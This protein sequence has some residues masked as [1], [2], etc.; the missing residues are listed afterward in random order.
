MKLLRIIRMPALITFSLLLTAV[1]AIALNP[2]WLRIEAVQ[3]DLQEGSQEE[4][5]FQRIK[6]SLQPQFDNF[7]GRYFWEL[8]LDTVFQTTQ[9]DRRVKKVSIFREFPSRLRI[10]VEPHTPVL[11]FLSTDHRIYP[12]ATDATL[13]PP[14]PAKEAP[15]LPL[16]RGEELKDEPSLRER[17]LEL[18][19]QI[20]DDGAI[21]KNSVSEIYY[22]KRDGFKVFVSGA[23]AEVKLGDTDFSPKISRVQKVL[24]Y[25]ESQNIKGRVIDARFQKK[26]VVRVRNTP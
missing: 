1:V 18:Y 14:L 10:V 24:S 20:P 3:I 2:Q 21:R 22:S 16:L 17:A 4:L 12:V 19:S 11:A 8:P 9:K 26:V 25:L 15:N 23:Q 7:A 5:L 6:K 13:L